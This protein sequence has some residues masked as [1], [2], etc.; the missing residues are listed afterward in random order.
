MEFDGIAAGFPEGYVVV[1]AVPVSAG[2]RRGP[3]REGLRGF[4]ADLDGVPAGVRAVSGFP[5]AGDYFLGFEG[6]GGCPRIIRWME[7]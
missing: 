2:D 4:R 1:A 6:V 5:G 3:G 7:D